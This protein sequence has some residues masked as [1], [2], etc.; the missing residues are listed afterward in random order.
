[1]SITLRSGEIHWAPSGRAFRGVDEDTGLPTAFA[2]G[3]E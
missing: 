3:D 2:E 1:M